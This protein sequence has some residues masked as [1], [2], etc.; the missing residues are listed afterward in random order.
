MTPQRANRARPVVIRV[1]VTVAIAVLALLAPTS[2]MAQPTDGFAGLAAG[3]RVY[4]ETGTSL[5]RPVVA[6]CARG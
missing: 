6:S 3:Q 5:T 1:V 2:A 4:D